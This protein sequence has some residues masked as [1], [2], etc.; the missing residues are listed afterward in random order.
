MTH[1][2]AVRMVR[3]K[4]NKHRRKVGNNTYAEILHDGSVGIMLHSTYVVRIHEDGTYTLNNGG[5]RTIITKDR[6]NKYC[7]YYV[8]QKNY[9]WFVKKG[10]KTFPFMSGMVIGN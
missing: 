10:D 3:G 6:I 5:W 7:P 4:T 8:F 9:E 2:E 1:S